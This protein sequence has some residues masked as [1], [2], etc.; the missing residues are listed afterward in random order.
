[1]EG[2]NK[3]I[4]SVNKK[5]FSR[6]Q[7]D[8]YLDHAGATVYAQSQLEALQRDLLENVYGNPH[9]PCASSRLSTDTIE[10]VRYR[11]LQHFNTSSDHHSVI[12][13]AG[14]TASLK[15]LAE[16]F[17][18]ASKNSKKVQNQTSNSPTE[19][20]HSGA[21]QLHPETASL[22]PINTNPPSGSLPSQNP[23]C[24]RPGL[25]CYLMDNHTSVVG[26]REIARMKGADVQCVAYQDIQKVFKNSPDQ[27]SKL[28]EPAKA[29]DDA[30][31]SSCLQDKQKSRNCLFAYPAQSNFSGAK[32]HL[33]DADFESLPFSS[34]GLDR[35]AVLL[36]AASLVGTSPLNL[37]QCKADF[38]SIS[39][40][41]IFG[42]P[43]GIGALIVRNDAA[44]LL[45]KTYFG[46]GTVQAYLARSQF[47]APKQSISDRF[48]DGTLPF[49]DIIA[50]KHGFDTLERL[51]G[52]MSTI[53][54]HTFC[55]ARYV[56]HR[57]VSYQHSNSAAVA[58]LYCRG[59]FESSY[60]QGPIVNFNLLRSTGDYVGYAQVERLASLHGIHLR[61]GCFC[62]TGA[63]Q[64]HVGLK[65][66][67][68]I[69]NFQAG[70]V[71]GDEMDLI[72]GRP[73]GSVRI[74]FGYMS[75]L[76][77]AETFLNFIA[78]CFVEKAH[79]LIE[80][81]SIVSPS[82]RNFSTKFD[83]KQS[84][85]EANS[86][87]TKGVEEDLTA[88]VYQDATLS[89]VCETGLTQVQE[90]S[91]PD[92]R[93]VVG[94]NGFEAEIRPPPGGKVL[95][96]IYLY[97]VKSCSAF[98][99]SEWEIGHSGL[100]YDRHWMVVNSNGVC[101]S[102]K[103]EERL[104]LIKPSIDLKNKCLWLHYQGCSSISVPLDVSTEAGQTMSKNH[105]QSKVCADRVKTLDC[106]EAVAK[107][108]SSAL[109]KDCRLLQ[110][111]PD[112]ERNCRLKGIAQCDAPS[113]QSLSLVNTAPFTLLC[114][115][116]AQA[117][118]STIRERYSTIDTQPITNSLQHPIDSS[119][120]IRANY[121]LRKDEGGWSNVCIEELIGRFRG[122]LVIDGWEA[123]DEDE[124]EKIQI[125]D[126]TFPVA[127]MCIRCQ[128]V[129][130]DPNTATRGKEPLLTLSSL[131]GKKIPFGTLLLHDETASVSSTLRV[132]DRVSIVQPPS[133]Y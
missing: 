93:Y 85:L 2:Y 75:T 54:D 132:G 18:W 71:C 127:G 32:Y 124:W 112:F 103:R 46:G 63:C 110:Q 78:E 27:T 48:E 123:F 131:R 7:G 10:Q 11:I 38:V 40:Y 45:H 116:S 24:G 107:W 41:K 5:E 117:L 113:N 133:A 15:L 14:C 58:K 29:S 62:N 80:A 3:S 37:G 95:T 87:K 51:A 53:S 50:L 1:M 90:T 105:A 102:L 17:D 55:L 44:R 52:S 79:R 92:S 109:G 65:D 6:L 35:W 23:A 31:N 126:H 69:V 108:L 42:F 122:N 86:F 88:A 8:T 39:F 21:S 34:V 89:Q 66:E 67:E 97:P 82:E 118:L 114:R 33:V 57:L 73:T 43:T 106:G 56:H 128:M 64:E 74:S 119:E 47:H 9:S 70:H 60:D 4:E 61:T 129:C 19:S 25:F 83:V 84:N 76:A 13:T 36:D 125:G 81:K 96:N 104:S 100:M 98:E 91:E 77:D 72:N 12:F 20:Q 16:S 49:L 94:L 115:P 22:N 121:P 68:I 101:L 99:V 26:M 30:Q 59:N 120:P 28:P 111:H 130:V